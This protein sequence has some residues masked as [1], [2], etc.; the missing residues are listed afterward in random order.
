MESDDV[1][2]V[3]VRRTGERA[4]RARNIRMDDFTV[5]A[6]VRGVR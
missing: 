1:A 3:K 5:L 6:P 2:A 4:K